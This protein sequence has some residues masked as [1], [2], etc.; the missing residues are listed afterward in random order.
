[1]KTPSG[2]VQQNPWLQVA[3]K[4]LE[5]MHKLLAEFGLTPASRS[6]VAAMPSLTPKPWED[7]GRPDSDD[8]FAGL[9]GRRPWEDDDDDPAAEYVN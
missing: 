7:F 1:M 2:H 8:E 9:I 3:N 6:R 4:A 5:Q